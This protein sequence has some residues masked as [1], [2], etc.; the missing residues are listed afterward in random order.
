MRML[1]VAELGGGFGHVRRLLP[2]ARAA[3]RLG[4]R[5][6]FLVANPSE[7]ESLLGSEFDVARA[8]VAPPR[9]TGAIG[10]A[11]A[12][13]FSEILARA[14]F[15]D[16]D[17]VARSTGAWRRVLDELRPSLAV[18]EFSPYFCWATRGSALEVLVTGYGFV[19]PPP[20]AARFPELLPT[21]VDLEPRLL[22]VL[23]AVARRH[24][25]PQLAAV[26]ELFRGTAHAVT[27]LDLLDP[28]ASV[29][30]EKAF[31]PPGLEQYR[32]R[33]EIAPVEDIFG[34][35]LGDAPD[36]T[37]LLRALVACGVSGRVYVRRGTA[38]QRAVVAGS[39]VAWLSAPESTATAFGRARL[40]V[41]HAS[42]LTSEESVVHGRA[43]LVLP[44]YFEHLFTARALNQAGCASIVRPGTALSVVTER[45][46]AALEDLGM[47]EA[48]RQLALANAPQLPGSERLL[49]LLRSVTE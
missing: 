40:I 3:E 10:S 25:Q 1:F 9:R 13:G 19:L 48:A 49:D 12:P 5:P 42:M 30:R 15:D 21:A 31:G 43:Q 7:V 47:Q 28:Y 35:L 4:F 39:S 33:G 32:S 2:L 16:A 27:G 37:T 18:C 23:N 17:F 46:R 14:G 6:T 29:R 38:E 26:P 22:D 41:H 34:Y 20:D 8:P 11:V 44:L 45:V 24:G 36:T